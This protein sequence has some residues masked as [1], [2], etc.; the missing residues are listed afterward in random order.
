MI[1]EVKLQGGGQVDEVGTLLLIQ[2]TL[3]KHARTV[4]RTHAASSSNLSFDGSSIHATVFSFINPRE[5]YFA[6]GFFQ[7]NLT[8]ATWWTFVLCASNAF[9]RNQNKT[10]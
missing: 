7:T 6:A 5:P 8:D 9:K 1:K 3:E 4:A 2:T 10:K